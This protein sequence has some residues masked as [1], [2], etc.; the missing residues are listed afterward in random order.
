[1]YRRLKIMPH[2]LLFSIGS[3]IHF[4]DTKTE[5]IFIDILEK[6]LDLTEGP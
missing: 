4:N 2:A 6:I 5:T 3:Y 1:M